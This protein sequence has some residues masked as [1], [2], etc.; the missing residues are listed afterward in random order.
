MSRQA[1]TA[2]CTPTPTQPR[3][4]IRPGSQVCRRDVSSSLLSSTLRRWP[5][6]TRRSRRHRFLNHPRTLT[7][8]NKRGPILRAERRSRQLPRNGSCDWVS[9]MRL[10]SVTTRTSPLKSRISSTVASTKQ[11][12]SQPSSSTS[13][14]T[15]RVKRRGWSMRYSPGYRV[16]RPARP[17]TCRRSIVQP[18]RYLHRRPM[19]LRPRSPGGARVQPASMRTWERSWGSEEQRL[20]ILSRTP[21]HPSLPLVRATSGLP[22]VA[23]LQFVVW[24]Q[25][26]RDSVAN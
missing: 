20:P 10:D 21:V 15:L 3:S 17:S 22:S 4:S 14:A 24:L 6:T 19:L 26:L 11:R 16:R 8:A 7:R 5:G 2:T 25:P 13:A 1:S 23:T 9:S 18:T 12:C